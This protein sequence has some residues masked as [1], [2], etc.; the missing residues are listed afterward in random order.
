MAS[1]IPGYKYDIFISYRQKDNKGERWVSEFVEALKIELESTF[2]EEV[3]VYFDINPHDGLLET[4]EVDESLKEKLNCLIF[5]PV[6]SRTYCDPRSFAWEHE[7]RAFVEQASQDTFGLKIKLPSGNVARRVLPVRIHELESEDVTLCETLIDGVLRGVEFIYKEPGVNR[8]LT[9]VD[10]EKLNLNKTKYRNQLNKVANAIHEIIKGVK[11]NQSVQ[12]DSVNVPEKQQVEPDNKKSGFNFLDFN[13]LY[14]TRTVV[15]SSFIL[16]LFII[17]FIFF[18]APRIDVSDKTMAILPLR[19]SDSDST[20]QSDADFFIEALID[21]LN[22]LKKIGLRPTISTL[23]YRNTSKTINEI[24]NALGARYLVY[25]NIRHEGDRI[26]IWIELSEAKRKNMLW[27]GS[28]DWERDRSSLII[29]NIVKSISQN[30]DIEL[31]LEDEKRL[32]SEPSISPSAN[33][34]YISANSILRDAWSYIN[35]GDRMLDSTS[36]STAILT[37]G[38]AIREDSLFALAYAKRALAIAWGYFNGQLD[39]TYLRQCRSDILKALSIDS[40]LPDIQTAQGFYSYYCEIDYDKALFH[41]KQAAE[42]DPYNYQPLYYQSLVYRKMGMWDQSQELLHSVIKLSPRE[43]LFLTNIGL[44]YTYVHK[45]DSAIIFHDKAI[46]VVPSWPALY[47]NKIIALLL[48]DG[49]TLESKSVLEEAIRNTGDSMIE[50]EILLDIYD[51]EYEKALEKTLKSDKS[52]FKYRPLRFI[53]LARINNLLG[54]N[55][56]SRKYCDSVLAQIHT[57]IISNPGSAELHGFTGLAYAYLGNRDY[58][59]SE[60]EKAIKLAQKDKMT[61]SDMK[62]NLAQIY[63]ILGDY[64]DAISQTAYLLNSQSVMSIGLLMLDPVWRPLI[65][66]P[67]NY[68]ALKRILK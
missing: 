35:Y 51:G 7:F 39:S 56:A 63:T 30:I 59:I 11:Y 62:I 61:E 27:S 33:Q 31:T 44:S 54:R 36:F 47:D 55:E 32:N 41:F 37:Y 53:Y 10:D 1:L 21:K 49:N 64:D 34:S 68:K 23:G 20:L 40:S 14:Q 38:R 3:S 25:G 52:N 5:I 12:K 43:A 4:H 24:S 57:D 60:G 6:I 50:Y 9:P 26:K 28:F 48:K 18:K 29:H 17:L 22:L 65:N 67:V 19:I 45:F 2:K 66:N 58:A 13:W 46:E 15:A 16:L 42:L 8:P